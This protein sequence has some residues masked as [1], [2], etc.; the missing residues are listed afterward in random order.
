MTRFTQLFHYSH[1]YLLITLLG[2]FAAQGISA[3]TFTTYYRFSYYYSDNTGNYAVCE[4]GT[5]WKVTTTGDGFVSCEDGYGIYLNL[6]SSITL[7]SE[8]VFAKNVDASIL[9]GVG[10]QQGYSMTVDCEDDYKYIDNVNTGYYGSPS[11][12]S[13]YS[14]YYTFYLNRN[15]PGTITFTVGNSSS[16]QTSVLIECIKI[17]YEGDYGITVTTKDGNDIVVDDNNMTNVLNEDVPTV[18]FDG[19]QRLTLNNADIAKVSVAEVNALPSILVVN[20]AGENKMQNDTKAFVNESNSIGLRFNTNETRPGSLQYTCTAGNLKKVDD[21]FTGFD[22]S[23]VA[24]LSATLTQDGGSSVVNVKELLDPI[25]DKDRMTITLEGA[26]GK[27]IGEDIEGYTTADLAAGVEVNNILYTLPAE[28]DGY[29][30]D[31][32]V[33]AADGKLVALNSYMTDNSIT[34]DSKDFIQKFHGMTFKL[35]PGIGTIKI[36]ARTNESGILMV[37][38]DDWIYG[39][40]CTFNDAK[41]EFKE[42][43]IIYKA[44][45]MMYVMIYNAAAPAASSNKHRAPG[46]KETATIEIKGVSVNAYAIDEYPEAQSSPRLLKKEDIN[47]ALKDGHIVINDPTVTGVYSGAFEDLKDKK[48]T[49]VDLSGTSIQSFY[50]TN[51]AYAGIPASTLLFLPAGNPLTYGNVVIG[52]ICPGLTLGTDI[53]FD[54][55]KDFM[56]SKMELSRD[57]SSCTE[58]GCTVYLPF[59]VTESVAAGWGT[60]YDLGNASVEG[61]QT[62]HPVTET[63]A[64]QPYLFKPTVNKLT[65]D[66]VLIKA[67]TEPAAS[68][69]SAAA[70]TL[71]GTYEAKDVVSDASA[72]YYTFDTAMGTFVKATTTMTVKP[73][74]AYLVAPATAP[75]TY[76]IVWSDIPSGIQQIK[77][78]RNDNIYY[79]LSG[80]RVLYPRKGLYIVNGKKVV[81]K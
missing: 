21:A 52:S 64:H 22:V 41:E 28:N 33:V 75:D 71:E 47:A 37:R 42:Y 77:V 55:P 68:R 17:E 2:L 53:P 74:E 29:I 50:R 67:Q 25:V 27:G 31:P 36:K 3:K 80:R 40:T 61:E 19:E 7:T 10:N 12:L 1:R 81:I 24:G 72:N 16:Y 62:V 48:V 23:Y 49:Y 5:R 69:R 56:A 44:P 76:S 58:K 66:N 30:S 13:D 15:S 57:F 6:G 11:S 4:D 78:G 70:T 39:K 32:A 35:P 63:M 54:T 9:T 20:L 46:R 8:K 51:N 34:P 18:Q 79:D 59:G 45:E 26:S 38:L 14:K 65:A 43:E 60:F 73:F